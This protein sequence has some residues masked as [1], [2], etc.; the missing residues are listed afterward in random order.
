MNVI[1]E[2][3]FKTSSAKRGFY[4]RLKDAKN[5]EIDTEKSLRFADRKTLQERAQDQRLGQIKHRIMRLLFCYL[6]NNP[7]LITPFHKP[8]QKTMHRDE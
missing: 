2:I 3:Q 1:G 7:D 4:R 8:T 5:L 6:Q